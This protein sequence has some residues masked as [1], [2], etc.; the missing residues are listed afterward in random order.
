[1]IENHPVVSHDDWLQ[2][3]TEFLATEKEFTRL[4]DELSAERRALPWERVEKEYVFDGPNGK[5][6]LAALFGAKRQLIVYHFMFDP[7]WDAGCKSCSFWADNFS[8][9]GPHLEH[10]DVSFV[11]ISRAPYAKLE[12]YR[13]RMGWSFTWLSSF[14]NPFNYDYLVSFTPEEVA[15]KSAF[16][17]YAIS[18]P[19][20]P[21]TVGI[22]VFHK[23]D[24]GQVYHTYSCYARGVDMMNG[25]YHYVD[26]TPK[27]RDEGERNQF[28]VR[29]RDEYD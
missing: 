2:A 14:E 8:R 9:I 12:A 11:A 7:S 27:G 16:Y 21:E 22:S 5:E 15:A 29:R 19:G 20:G 26:L 3:R 25:A 4:R 13:K 6:S 17:N 28:W 10:R 18:N 23:D 1:M 24:D